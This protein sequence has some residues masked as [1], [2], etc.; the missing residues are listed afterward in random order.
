MRKPPGEREGSDVAEHVA[1]GIGNLIAQHVSVAEARDRPFVTLFRRCRVPDP[2]LAV[3][4]RVSGCLLR[5]RRSPLRLSFLSEVGFLSLCPRSSAVC[6]EYSQSEPYF[7]G[8]LPLVYNLAVYGVA[9]AEERSYPI[10]HRRHCTCHNC[11]PRH[12]GRTCIGFW[13]S[14]LQSETALSV[15]VNHSA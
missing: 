13:Q 11:K 4:L 10:R 3:A 15:V 12:F 1:P 8:G 14:H 9:V 5:S 6:V 7:S 2:Y